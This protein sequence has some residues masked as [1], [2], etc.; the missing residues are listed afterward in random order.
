M[1]NPHAVFFVR[2]VAG[3]ALNKLGPVIEHHPVFPQRANVSFAEVLNRN[4]IRLRVWERSAGA[5]LACGSAACA[6]A[7]AGVRRGVL[8]RHARVTL[9][10]GELEIEWRASDSHVVMTGETEIEHAGVLPADLTGLA[11]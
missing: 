2:D 7:V 3:V 4:A 1:G 5:T 11:A 10:G 8:D 6:A 9:P